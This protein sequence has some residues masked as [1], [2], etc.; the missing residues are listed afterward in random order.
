MPYAELAPVEREFRRALANRRWSSLVAERPDLGPAVAL[1]RALLG[2]VLSLAERFD[3]EQTPRLSLPPRYVTT[4]LRSGIPALSG[5]RIPLPVDFLAPALSRLAQ[6][7]ALGGG[8]EATLRI[9][10]AI[11]SGSLDAEA[12]LTLGLRREQGS[13]RAV[14]THAGLGHDL[15]WLV[16]DLA[17]SPYANRLLRAVFGGLAPDSPLRVAL[18]EWAHGYCPLCGSWPT[19][20]E[21]VQDER[22][23]RCS[24]CA[25][26]WTLPGAACIYCGNAGD[27]FRSVSPDEQHPG[28]SV[29]LCGACK[30]YAKTLPV[31]ASAQ[32]PLVAIA[33]LGSMDLDMAAMQAGF[34]RPALRQFG[35][36]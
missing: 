21:A 9:R 32:F 24:C 27:T 22:R 4:K 10:E 5:E 19:L 11:D 17:I 20:V 16:V 36:R 23:L 14:A 6:S 28:R 34:S 33:D 13:L 26:A 8:G 1:Q 7:L 12:L 25:C 3:T 31:V 15:L 29:E 2:E 30:G 35:R 18:D